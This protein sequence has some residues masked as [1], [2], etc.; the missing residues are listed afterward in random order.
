MD[1]LDATVADAAEIIELQKLAFLS[2]ALIYDD[3]AIPPLTQTVD[4]LLPD[5][6]RTTILKAVSGGKIIGSVKGCMKEG[7]C[8]IGRLMVHP[9]FRR[10]GIGARLMGAIEAR[11]DTTQAW[12]LFTGEL[13]LGNMRLYERLGY[14]VTR[15]E[16]FDGSSFAVV[17]MSKA[18]QQ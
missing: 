11:F 17:I 2:E 12:E 13:S 15:T 4:D 9:D 5:F 6:E 14:V 7:I 10:Q 1:I 18:R 8:L 16:S 3:Y